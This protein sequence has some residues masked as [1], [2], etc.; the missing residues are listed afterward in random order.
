MAMIRRPPAKG[1]LDV[2]I[3]SDRIVFSCA[4]QDGVRI[5]RI[6][7]LIPLIVNQHE[8]VGSVRLVE[9]KQDPKSCWLA[10]L[11]G[12]STPKFEDNV[13]RLYDCYQ[14]HHV[15]DWEMNDDVY[16]VRLL[17]DTIVICQET[18][19]S[20]WWIE[21]DGKYSRL[22]RVFKTRSNKRGICI[23]SKK[24][25][26]RY[27]L[28][29]PAPKGP[30]CLQIE[31]INGLDL[32]ADLPKS[33]TAKE[34]ECAGA[35]STSPV[36]IDA[37]QHELACAAFNNEGTLVATSSEHGTLIRIHDTAT[38]NML[39]ELRRGSDPASIF[40]LAFSFDSSYLC[41]SSDKG[42]VHIFSI[43]KPKLNQ[44][45]Q[46]TGPLSRWVGLESPQWSMAR[47][48]VLGE[49]ACQCAFVK[50]DEVVALCIDGSYH[51][52]KFNEEGVCTRTMYDLYIHIHLAA[53]RL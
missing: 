41:V 34:V 3:R 19:I 20:V 44:R 26:T 47:F 6:D 29:F 2:R 35:S 36:V 37:H 13:V 27:L 32:E 16:N 21:E 30:G 28:A 8:D 11:G 24:S 15:L 50:P 5:Y 52:Y 43:K 14:N 4:L 23:A 51:R 39:L 38:R 33:V 53:E 49:S 48:T 12:G 25:S 31:D 22:L 7:P 45:G 40:C 18:K 9:M 42:T 46:V 1:I 10:L 17:E